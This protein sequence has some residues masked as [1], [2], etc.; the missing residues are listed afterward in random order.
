MPVD[1]PREM[2]I[3]KLKSPWLPAKPM[4]V[5]VKVCAKTVW[6]VLPN[7]HRALVGSSAFQTLAAADRCRVALMQK[8]VGNPGYGYFAPY[9]LE[10]AKRGLGKDHKVLH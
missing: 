3:V 7:G 4:M 8:I 5:T 6:A 2:F 10:S 1:T 9:A